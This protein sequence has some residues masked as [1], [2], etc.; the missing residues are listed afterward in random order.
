MQELSFELSVGDVLQV[1]D[2]LVTVVDIDGPEV[3]FRID[4]LE[5]Q[6][7]LA[8]EYAAALPAR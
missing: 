6:D 4:P 3:T 5:P 8:E 2:Q 1:G 7:V